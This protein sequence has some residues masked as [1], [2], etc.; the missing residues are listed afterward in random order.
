MI[1]PYPSPSPIPTDSEPDQ[2]DLPGGEVKEWHF[3]IYWHTQSP[4]SRSAA[5]YLRNRILHLTFTHYFTA[6]PLPTINDSPI[7]PHPMSSY[8]VWVPYE[9]FARFYSWIVLNRPKD[10]SVMIHPLTRE[11]VK[12]HTERAVFLGGTATLWVGGLR[13]RLEDVPRQYPELGLGY[14]APDSAAGRVRK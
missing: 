7:G 11:E 2:V 13:E 5:L 8:E 14:S 3:H 10:V 6:K 1:I 9:S 4:S 12:D